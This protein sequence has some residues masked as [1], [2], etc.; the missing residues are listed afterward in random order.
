MA[1]GFDA[2]LVLLDLDLQVVGTIVGGHE[3]GLGEGRAVEVVIVPSAAGIGA[4]V[5]DV[6]QALLDRRPDAVLGLATGSSPLPVYDELVDRFARG[7]VSFRRARRLPARR[8]R[9]AAAGHPAVLPV[10]SSRRAFTGQVDLAPGSVLGPDGSACD[11][12]A[13]CRAY[14]NAIAAAGGVDLQLL[15]VGA[16]G[17][18]AFNEPGSSL[19]VP[20]PPQDADAPDAGGQRPLLR[21]GSTTCRATC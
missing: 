21:L 10:G 13:A 19:G 17:H 4:L 1:P 7:Q 5:A 3:V 20:H 18:I 16:D 14:E 8:V 6:V 2:D 9:R 15:G 12:V 11:L